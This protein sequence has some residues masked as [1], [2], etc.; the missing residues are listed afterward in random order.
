MLVLLHTSDNQ[1][2]LR[3]FSGEVRQ[4]TDILNIACLANDAESLRKGTREMAALLQAIFNYVVFQLN[5]AKLVDFG[6]ESTLKSLI[7]ELSGAQKAYVSAFKCVAADEVTCNRSLKMV[8]RIASFEKLLLKF[9]RKVEGN[10]V[11]GRVSTHSLS[12]PMSD[13]KNALLVWAHKNQSNWLLAQVSSRLSSG[14]R[15]NWPRHEH[16]RIAA[17]L[18]VSKAL[19]QSCIGRL[20]AQGKVP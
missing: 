14:P 9:R 12:G 4:A 11:K 13:Q 15:V 18:G 6:N 16:K 2:R 20:I 8:E 1:R 19:V 17:E 5:Q 10:L 3:A 7:N